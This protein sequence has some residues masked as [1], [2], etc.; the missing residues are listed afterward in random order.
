MK[1]QK[2]I[3]LIAGL[4]A[5]FYL[6]SCSTGKEVELTK[7]IVWDKGEGNV[8]GYR[9]PGIVVSPK[10]TVLAF[11]E[12]RIDYHDQTPN[13]IVLKRSMD[14]GISWSPSIM[15][16]ESNGS[17]WTVH[18]ELIDPLDNPEKKEVWTNIAPV[19]DYETGRI[20]FFYSLNEGEIAGMNLQRYTKVF[21]K[22][23]DDDGLSWS[24]RKEITSLLHVKEGGTPN[25]DDSGSYI[26][27]VNGFPCD[28]LGRAFHMPG[29]GHGIQLST[30]R[31]LLQIWNR[32]ALGKISEDGISIP[33]SIENRKYG[34]STIYSDDHGDTWYYGSSFGE[35]IHM[36]E[37]RIVELDNG[38]VYINARY[39]IPDKTAHRAT[40]VS[41]DCGKN[42]N[43][44]LIDTTFP[45]TNQC[46]GGLNKI[47]DSKN[48][49]SYL[50]YSKNESVEGRKNLTVRLSEDNGKTWPIS[51][52]IDTG[53]ASYSDIA[54]LPDH[55]ILILYETGKGKPVYCI[56]TNLEW[57]LDKKDKLVH[58][59]NCETDI[60]PELPVR[61]GLGGAF[62]GTHND[63]LI[64]AG[65]SYFD[66]SLWEDGKKIYTDSI[67]VCTRLGDDMKWSFAGR[68]PHP[69]AHGAS[70]STNRGLVCIGGKTDEENFADVW[71]LQWDPSEKKIRIETD[72]P[73][74]PEACA[75]SSAAIID[76][77]IFIAGGLGERP[78]NTFRKLDF[79]LGNSAQWQDINQESWD[80]RYGAALI[81]QSNGENDCLYLFGGKNNSGYLTDAYCYN[82][83]ST[84][85]VSSQWKRL[86]DIPRPVFGSP[87]IAYSTSN[88]FLFSG[89]DGHDVD[90]ILQIKDNYRFTTDILSFNTITQE[91]SS[92]GI[93]PQGVVNTPAIQWY[94]RI[95]IPGGEIGPGR[96]TPQIFTAQA[97][98]EEKGVFS[99]LDYTT[100]IAYLLLIVW[101]GYYFSKKNKSSKDFFLGGQKIPFWAA[102]LSMMAAQV[103]SIGFMSIP[104][105]SFITNWSYFAGVMT[106]FI[107]VPVVIYAFVP[108]YRRLNVTSAYEYLEKRFNVFIRK[109]VAFL[110]LL[111]QLLGRLGAIIFL[112]AIAL[113]AVTGMDTLVCI[114]IIGGLATLY[115]VLGGMHAVIWIDVIQALVLFG[116]IFLCIGYVVTNIDG[117]M[118]GIFAVAAS[119]NKFSL[120]RMDW[121]MTAAVFWVIVIGNIF[122]RIGGMAT[123]QSVVQR[124]LTTKNEKETAKA[125]WTDA[126]VSIPWALCVFG[127]GTALYVFYKMNPEML[128]PSISNDEVVPFFIG[129]NLPVGLSGIVIA[130][131]FAASMSSV[132][133]SIHSS[134]TVI[135]RDF[136]QGILSRI[137][138]RRNVKTARVI[139][140]LIGI[141]GTGIAVIMTFFDI[142][143][144][145]DIILEF[146]G[147]FT[148]AMTGVFI[149]GIF[150]SR[151]NGKGTVVGV[152]ASAASLLYI[153]T[154]TPLNF[155][156]Y[157]GIGIVSCVLIG[158]L[159][160]FLFKSSKSTQGLTIYSV[161]LK[162]KN[163]SE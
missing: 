131:I 102:G 32:T 23:S 96:R 91:W 59:I 88:V 163:K 64:I 118:S 21:Y 160:S 110:Y 66:A 61:Q 89:S 16:E 117:G 46:D 43:D 52:T 103:S 100:L 60:I 4:L 139:T 136:M 149:L 101:L 53:A 155:F 37:S 108:F 50:I 67:F 127:L 31:L 143:S 63:V 69:I 56:R 94:D 62:A 13:H 34:I 11:V 119:D 132:D 70:V 35:D 3:H 2:I 27:D 18:K 86:P 124:Y 10:G 49:K 1:Q 9:I 97:K 42:W 150:S 82:Y 145:W 5:V 17:Y 75:Y 79:R 99:I 129:Q 122:N 152:I 157:S 39:T 78:L 120:G 93:M 36:N 109:F 51:K 29:P 19:V 57:I 162:E 68:L 48:G 71:L 40:A 125:L 126:L 114:V 85:K 55:T 112:P 161:G 87:A 45:L 22:Y 158:Y 107:V 72:F 54:I 106:W 58:W 41:H 15:I 153:K 135:M 115:T 121:D 138:E 95:V 92:V 33:I 7:S 8:E 80:A 83:N 148:G 146:A 24:E 113:S 47:T 137:S 105:K 116:A 151:A 90:K 6:F 26:R 104:A 44:A 140:T 12:A 133:S 156:L 30:G 77:Y 20:F 147:L 74:L 28:H 130:G 73:S 142:N 76:N 134:T 38:D 144:V 25:T 154:F 141:L 98:M 128:N 84:N 81:K 14:G 65:G 123:D 159:A 111:F